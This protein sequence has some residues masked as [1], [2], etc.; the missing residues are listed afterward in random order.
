MIDH[1]EL[2]CGDLC[3]VDC[4]SYV[5]GALFVLLDETTRLAVKGTVPVL[6]LCMD[7][8]W[9]L[10]WAFVLIEGTLGYLRVSNLAV[11]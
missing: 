7:P 11:T 4:P 3:F 1:R 6:F 10:N 8:R 5:E 9:E 2:R